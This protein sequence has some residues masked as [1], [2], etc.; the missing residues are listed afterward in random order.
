VTKQ[1]EAWKKREEEE[2]KIGGMEENDALFP[3]T[4]PPFHPS[5]LIAPTGKYGEI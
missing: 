2:W 1:E 4:L 3:S 5:S